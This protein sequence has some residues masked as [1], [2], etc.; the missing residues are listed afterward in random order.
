MKKLLIICLT[1][2]LFSAF[3][4]ELLAQIVENNSHQNT[5]NSSVRNK[6]SVYFLGVKL[7]N[8]VGAMVV[9]IEQKKGKKILSRYIEMDRFMLGSNYLSEDGIPVVLINENLQDSDAKKLEAIITHELLHLRLR[10]N[11]YP[12]FLFSERVNTAKGRAIDTE[13]DTLNDLTSL[14]EHRIFKAELEKFDLYKYINLAGD[15]ANE[16]RKNKGDEDGQ[17]NAIDYARAILEYQNQKDID[18][19][20]KA[21]AANNWTRSLRGG[22]AIARIIRE[23]NIQT[24]NEVDAVFIKCLLQL[25]PLPGSVYIYKLT[26]DPNKKVGRRMI[27]S[28]ERRTAVGKRSKRN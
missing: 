18:E 27:V 6:T 9:E 23:A 21:Y 15:T 1:I 11:G 25:F 12:T 19:V 7:Q 20:K 3:N 5:E 4:F 16:A 14:I 28:I 17:S 26:L 13:Q 22:E 8:E 10:V 2:N 24:P